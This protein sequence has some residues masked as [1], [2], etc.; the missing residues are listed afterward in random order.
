MKRTFTYTSRLVKIFVF[1]TICLSASLTSNA[2]MV[3]VSEGFD[4]N[5]SGSWPTGTVPGGWK[6]G[7][8]IGTGATNVFER[9]ATG[10]NPTCSPQA[11]A[12]MIRYGSWG[13]AAGNEAFLASRPL[14][15][16][17]RGAIS[18]NLRFWFHRDNGWAGWPDRIEVYVNTSPSM[19]GATLLTDTASGL[20]TIHRDRAM[21]PVVATNGWYKYGFTI[22]NNVAFNVIKL[23]VIVKAISGFGNNMFIDEFSVDTYPGTQT[24]PASGSFTLTSQNATNTGIGLTNQWIIGARIIGVGQGTTATPAFVVNTMTFTSGGCTNVSGDVTTARLW[25]TGGSSVFNLG[26]AIPV[27]TV[28]S[29]GVSYTFTAINT[30]LQ[31]DSNYF[32]LTY[33]ISPG[34]TPGNFVDAELSGCNATPSSPGGTGIP[35][36][37]TLAGE[38][39]I[40]LPYCIPTYF[41]GTAWNNYT[42]ND[43]V[44]RVQ[45]P[46][47]SGTYIDN[48]VNDNCPV[49]GGPYSIHP[50]D[51]QRFPAVTGRYCILK[52][53][54]ATVY[55]LTGTV[56]T[57]FSGNCLAAWID[58]N[59]DGDFFDAGE[60]LMQTPYPPGL[61]NSGSYAVNFTVPTSSYLG[62]TT[63]R[64]REAW[65]NNNIDPCASYTYGETEDYSVIIVPDCNLIPG[66]WKVWLG[67]FDDDWNNDLNWCGGKPTNTS[68]HIALI[69]DAA[70]TGGLVNPPNWPVIKKNTNALARRIRLEG[71]GNLTMNASKNSSLTLGDSLAISNASSS[72]SVITSLRDSLEISSGKNIDGSNNAN[73][74]GGRARQR[75]FIAYRASDLLAQGLDTND[76]IDSVF[77]LVKQRRST[78]PYQNFT[79]KYYFANNS[80]NG[81]PANTINWTGLPLAAVGGGPWTVL[82]GTTIDLTAGPDYI[83]LALTRNVS[84]GVVGGF[85]FT[86]SSAAGLA[87]GMSISGH[88]GIANGAV[89]TNIAGTTITV[90]TANVAA[91]SSGSA[92]FFTGGQV[93]IALTTP[94]VW[95]DPSRTL[96]LEI[97]YDNPT[98]GTV[99]DELYYTGTGIYRSWYLLHQTNNGTPTGCSLDCTSNASGARVSN[100]RRPN[101]TFTF[102]RP[103]IK[104][105]INIAGHWI[106]NGTFNRGWSTVTFNGGGA[107]QIGGTS[108]TTFNDVVLNKGI[109]IEVLQNTAAIVDSFMTLTGG[110]FRLNAQ[111]LTLNYGDSTALKYTANGSIRSEDLPPNYGLVNWKNIGSSVQTYTF[112]F[113]TL[114]TALIP[115]SVNINGGAGH[116]LTVGTYYP[117]TNPTNLL[118]WPTGVTNLVNYQNNPVQN[119]SANTVRRFW[120]ITDPSASPTGDFTFAYDAATESPGAGTVWSQRWAA[121]WQPYTAGQTNP[122]SN[123]NLSPSLGAWNTPWVLTLNTAPLPVELLSFTAK[124][125][126]ARVQLDWTT[127][128]EINNDYFSIDRTQS[129][130]DYTFIDMVRS[131]GPST[132]EQSY[133]TYDESPLLGTQYYRLKQV[134]FNGEFKYYGPIA[135]TFGKKE[136]NIVSVVNNENNSYTIV[137]NYNSELPYSYQLIDAMGRLITSGSNMNAQVGINHLEISQDI[138]SGVYT[139]IINNT[140]ETASKKFMK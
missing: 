107:Q 4:V 21:T 86:V 19:T 121:G 94:I 49:A 132:F 27:S 17:N 108:T 114:G 24:Y 87:V 1:I 14:D 41:T 96:I 92:N 20:T 116:E 89:I 35:T 120:V 13:I 83:P 97:C 74:F 16:R 110:I 138:A 5:N 128:T 53:D 133:R 90:S 56:G 127:A 29:P 78:Q 63:L 2:Q 55:T 85:T 50:P 77:I 122:T 102:R 109:N 6:Q 47:E 98:A 140:E 3:V 93:K 104:Y 51:Y 99:S 106:N 26:N 111:T 105:P 61:A 130:H 18:S 71:T 112:P 59:H 124:P 12:G 37:T 126:G 15:F 84:G 115:F 43:Y 118:P 81:F 103:Y 44:A 33:D 117:S 58:Y 45:L 139:V 57:Y 52:A 73:I 40:D 65:I 79:I 100:E 67:G 62:T 7:K 31:N 69:T 88:P 11:G 113:R 36:V 38:R 91:I 9:Y 25:F 8:I 137:F 54:A 10:V 22:P 129:G 123:T 75:M 136:F 48:N 80:V 135:V 23:Y 60:K 39:Q 32:W 68:T 30:S 119:T 76:V 34:A 70:S 64:V 95:S 82:P 125:V 134:D 46:G 28:A 72:V 101:I 42:N 66:G 131:Q